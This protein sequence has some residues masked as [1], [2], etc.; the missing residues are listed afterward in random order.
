MRRNVIFRD[1]NGYKQGLGP[2]VPKWRQF[3]DLFSW[4]RVLKWGRKREKQRKRRLGISAVMICFTV[5]G[6]NATNFDRKTLKWQ[7]GLFQPLRLQY[8]FR[9]IIFLKSGF[10]GQNIGR[11]V[12]FNFL[13]KYW[14]RL[15][16]G[17]EIAVFS[18]S[19]EVKVYPWFIGLWCYAINQDDFRGT[20]QTYH[21]ALIW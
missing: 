5:R 13:K 11:S 7:T 10:L 17:G 3:S 4:D 12:I 21:N 8:T 9:S 14:K 19:P 6:W 1:N 20:T 16:I 2:L 15:N 18:F